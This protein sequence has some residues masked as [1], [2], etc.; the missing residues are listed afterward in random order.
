MDEAQIYAMI[1][2]GNFQITAIL[3]YSYHFFHRNQLCYAFFFVFWFGPVR[4][5]YSMAFFGL[6]S[7][8]CRIFV[9]LVFV[10]EEMKGG[11]W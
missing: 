7:C 8:Y 2:C 3:L 9:G 10:F 4:L 1:V 5:L 11:L 6:H